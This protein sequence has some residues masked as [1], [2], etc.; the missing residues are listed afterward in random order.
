[1]DTHPWV[2]EDNEVC[3]LHFRYF[4]YG[5]AIVVNPV[6]S[7]SVYPTLDA[8]WS[9]WSPV[10]VVRRNVV[11][12]SPIAFGAGASSG[13]WVSQ[14]VIEDNVVV[15]SGLG[16][17]LDTGSLREFWLRNNVFLDIVTLGQYGQAL[18][19][20]LTLAHHAHLKVDNNAVRIRGRSTA[21]ELK[22]LVSFDYRD[23]DS[24]VNGESFSDPNLDLWRPAQ[25]IAGGLMIQGRADDIQMVGNRFSTWASGSGVSGANKFLS[26][27]YP[28]PMA[29]TSGD[30]WW[31][32]NGTVTADPIVELSDPNWWCMVYPC[33]S[34]TAGSYIKFS[35]GISRR[36]RAP[37]TNV[38]FQQNKISS[39]PY[40]FDSVGETIVPD[41]ILSGSQ[42]L[43][44]NPAAPEDHTD[45]R[46]PKVALSHHFQPIGYIGRVLPMFEDDSNFPG[47]A[48]RRKLR[49]VL[50]VALDQLDYNPATGRI[51]VRARVAE[52]QVPN[53]SLA[54]TRV[55]EEGWV[56]VRF[57][58]VGPS[59]PETP[60]APPEIPGSWSDE[61]IQSTYP[62]NSQGFVNFGVDGPPNYAGAL[63]ARVWIDGNEEGTHVGWPTN[64]AP[65]LPDAPP[66]NPAEIRR[67]ARAS[68][69]PAES[70]TWE[71]S[72]DAWAQAQIT[73]GRAGA[74]A[75]EVTTQPDATNERNGKRAKLMFSR[76]ADANSPALTVNFSFPTTGSGI[77]RPGAYGNSGSGDYYFSSA[78]VPAS[79]QPESWT[80]NASGGTI[81]F[82]AGKSQAVIEVVPRLD[83]QFER[84]T[85]YVALTSGT[86]YT[87][88]GRTSAAIMLY[89]SATWS[90]TELTSTV[91]DS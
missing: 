2:V 20:P 64:P 39:R 6:H 32:P 53:P 16:F 52:H 58:L 77:V 61:I 63:A 45:R 79:L 13:T 78:S 71:E 72:R 9:N 38:K 76:L 44:S 12:G 11:R 22:S 51:Q 41:Q 73:V 82:Q 83:E 28:M 50:E 69:Q 75:V 24:D 88:A 4:A 35:S 43:L 67:F 84:E 25:A 26:V 23:F 62:F 34:L 54:P 57:E 15:N 33:V 80:A 81:R 74:D 47:I 30:G 70:E 36:K 60:T 59:P 49:G 37:A 10:A 55:R 18:V 31:Y 90:L 8:Q 27:P 1:M 91:S 5:T 66:K 86:G 14:V 85:A 3:Q 42:E 29:A 17:N 19:G 21:A 7:G 40:D 89:D 48:Q 46:I 56:T 68:W 87:P 65:P